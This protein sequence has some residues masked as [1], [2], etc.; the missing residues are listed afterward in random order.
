MEDVRKGK[1]LIPEKYG[2]ILCPRCNGLGKIYGS[3]RESQVCMVCGGFGAIRKPGVREI[4]RKN[5]LRKMP[6][7]KF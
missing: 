1:T 6:E 5:E 4:A 3:G 7:S 2:M